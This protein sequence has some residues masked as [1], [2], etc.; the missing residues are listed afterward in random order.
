MKGDLD[1]ILVH[2]K[3]ASQQSL[4]ALTQ[5]LHPT[6][7]HSDVRQGIKLGLLNLRCNCHDC[8][9]TP[10]KKTYLLFFLPTEHQGV[11]K[12]LFRNVRTF[13]DQIG[14]WKCW[15]LRRGENRHTRRKTFWSRVE[16][17]QTQPTY[18]TGPKL[19]P[20]HIGGR[21]ALSPLRQHCS[22]HEGDNGVNA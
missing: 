18:D 10:S 14:I 2:S 11:H 12:N 6:T 5:I 22:P 13:Q 19:N 20:G 21:R 8:S 7:Q 1:R 16:N 15:F 17:Q 9:T 3:V 4:T